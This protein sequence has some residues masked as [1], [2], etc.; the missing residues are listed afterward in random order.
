MAHMKEDLSTHMHV[1][2][3]ADLGEDLVKQNR[4]RER[5]MEQDDLE[6]FQYTLCQRND[7][8]W[9]QLFAHFQALF[10]TWTQNHPQRDLASRYHA[11]DSYVA[12]QDRLDLSTSPKTVPHLSTLRLRVSFLNA[13]PISCGMCH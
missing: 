5:S 8:A 3:L 9:R 7:E 1:V 2:A 12:Y 6:V 4:P 11:L 10:Q 13:G